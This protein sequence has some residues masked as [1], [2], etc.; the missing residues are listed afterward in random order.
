M[1][2]YVP[3]NESLWAR[4]IATEGRIITA[5]TNA[6]CLCHS[7]IS[8]VLQ[9]DTAGLGPYLWLLNPSC[10][11]AL[12][13]RFGQRQWNVQNES[14]PN[15]GPRPVGSSCTYCNAVVPF[16]T[17]SGPAAAEEGATSAADCPSS[18]PWDSGWQFNRL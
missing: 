7:G 2:C 3:Y 9:G 16:Q 4:Q 17:H 13:S 14:Q 8:Y 15:Q 1:S 11:A 10:L 5:Y 18:S 12:P 6:M